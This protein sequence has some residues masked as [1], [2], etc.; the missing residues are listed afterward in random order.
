MPYHPPTS[1]LPI[2]RAHS[3]MI[4]T[5]CLPMDMYFNPAACPTAANVSNFVDQSTTAVP[6]QQ[7]S[8]FQPTSISPFR[9]AP[10]FNFDSVSTSPV[11]PSSTVS[12]SLSGIGMK[13]KKDPNPFDPDPSPR[14]KR[15]HYEDRM[16]RR[17]TS[18]DLSADGSPAESSSNSP[19]SITELLSE[20]LDDAVPMEDDTGPTVEHP[21]DSDDEAEASEADNGGIK[22]SDDLRRYFFDNRQGPVVEVESSSECDPASPINARISEVSSDSDDSLVDSDSRQNGTSDDTMMEDDDDSS[23]NVLVSF[24]KED[25]NSSESRDSS[26]PS[27]GNE[28]RA[29]RSSSNDAPGYCDF[30]SSQSGVRSSSTSS[31]SSD[32]R[33]P[34]RTRQSTLLRNNPPPVQPQGEDVEP[35]DID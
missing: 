8:L 31:S 34:F 6:T 3:P 18:L 1:K 7:P 27:S 19:L 33:R 14:S 17:L 4:A 24:P 16:S 20:P 2:S 28:S 30:S 21:E 35:M 10:A 32:D 29:G 15:R 11:F 9:C 13:R 12:E 23:S 5:S 25:S 22:L 26:P